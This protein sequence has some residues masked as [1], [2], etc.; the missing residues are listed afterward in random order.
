MKVLCILEQT[1]KWLNNQKTRMKRGMAQG[2]PMEG[3][4]KRW[5]EWKG[6][7]ECGKWVGVSLLWSKHN[8]GIQT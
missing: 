7:S 5:T 8:H 3:E 1:N 2:C 6:V 4:T